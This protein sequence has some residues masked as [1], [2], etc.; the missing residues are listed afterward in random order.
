MDIFMNGLIRMIWNWESYLI[1]ILMDL[2][3]KSSYNNVM[4]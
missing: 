1:V 4:K 2:L 3:K